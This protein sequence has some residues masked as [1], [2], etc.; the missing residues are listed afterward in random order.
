MQEKTSPTSRAIAGGGRNP[1]LHQALSANSFTRT[2]VIKHAGGLYLVSGYN[3]SGLADGE[4][5]NFVIGRVVPSDL[6]GKKADFTFTHDSGFVYK[7]HNVTQEEADA[8]RSSY[9]ASRDS[10]KLG[11]GAIIAK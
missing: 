5:V 6:G 10:E 9:N 4:R 8:V 1:F 3:E 2:F 11:G 7:L